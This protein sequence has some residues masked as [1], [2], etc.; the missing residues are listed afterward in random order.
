MSRR[1][2]FTLLEL[3]VVIAIFAVLVGLLLPAIQKVREAAHLMESTNNL[4]QNIIATH[5][6]AAL[7]EGQLPSIDGSPNS[8]NR[9]LSL[10]LA[11]LPY[12]EQST[13]VRR[14][15]DDR[16]AAVSTFVSPADPT[17]VSGVS[18]PVSSYA[19]NAQ[20]FVGNP[21]MAHTF[22]DGAS[23]T[24]AFAEHYSTGC[25][26]VTFLYAESGQ[27]VP[28]IMRRATFADGGPAI[29]PNV[30]DIYPITKGMPPLS[31]PSYPNFTF[32]VAPP[33]T[34]CISW[35]AQTPHRNGM[36][37][38]MGDGSVGTLAPSIGVNVYW[39]LVTPS[40]G[41]SVE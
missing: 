7:H 22:L 28:P 12:L 2:G 1:G 25:Q 35:V 3:L 9:G 39:G 34:K 33:V 23:R 41:E 30:G 40:G 14:P 10:F 5:N 11:I 20:V 4:R 19:A 18:G 32:Q 21:S 16:L 26:G 8:P 24:I 38:A 13:L 17:Y 27:H 29:K 6:F 15:G 31:E 36:L 37:A